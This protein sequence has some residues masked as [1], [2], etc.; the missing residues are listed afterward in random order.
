MRGIQ[1]RSGVRVLSANG[2]QTLHMWSDRRL[3]KSSVVYIV[4]IVKVLHLHLLHVKFK[5]CCCR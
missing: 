1:Y 2:K 3:A 5:I 4:I